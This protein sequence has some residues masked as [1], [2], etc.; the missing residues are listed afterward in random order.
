MNKLKPG[1]WGASSC[2]PTRQQFGLFYSFSDLH[3]HYAQYQ[4]MHLCGS[5]KTKQ[6]QTRT[7]QKPKQSD[8]K[9]LIYA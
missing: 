6:P 9:L 5:N 7:M 8:K 4:K 2:H 1:Y 3:W